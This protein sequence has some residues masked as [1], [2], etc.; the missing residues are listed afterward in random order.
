M[1]A[2]VVLMG[3]ALP[4]TASLTFHVSHDDTDSVTH[5]VQGTLNRASAG[6]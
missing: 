6:R 3:A 2:L 4:A 5:V 1:R